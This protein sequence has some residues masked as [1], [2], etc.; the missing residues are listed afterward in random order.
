MKEKL[1]AVQ[2]VTLT[3][4]H[5]LGTIASLMESVKKYNII[6]LKF[7]KKVL[8]LV[9]RLIVLKEY[10]DKPASGHLAFQRTY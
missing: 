8:P 9:L 10:H 5:A 6:R 7:K 4:Q 1:Q 2:E 3:V